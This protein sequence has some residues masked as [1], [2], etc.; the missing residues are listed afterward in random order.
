MLNSQKTDQLFPDWFLLIFFFN[1]IFS[2]L[3]YIRLDFFISVWIF[4]TFIEPW[5]TKFK[6]PRNVDPRILK[7]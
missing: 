7:L 6:D 4:T 1:E 2:A 5:S 3:I